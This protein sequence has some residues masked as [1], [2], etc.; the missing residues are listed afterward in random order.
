MKIDG[1]V[2]ATLREKFF[3]KSNRIWR[4]INI[5]LENG[6]LTKALK[7]I[8]DDL[9]RLERLLEGSAQPSA[10]GQHHKRRGSARAWQN[11]RESAKRVFNAL[12]SHWQCSCQHAHEASL[13]LEARKAQKQADLGVRFNVLFSFDANAIVT[14]KPPWEWRN[15]E[16]ESNE[17]DNIV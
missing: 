7:I 1:A 17:V 2:E 11:I 10:T 14:S 9:F 16:I 3:S 5:G 13:R 6:S 12:A 15:V 8:E 4:S